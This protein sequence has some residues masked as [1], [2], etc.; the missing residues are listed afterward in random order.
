MC[1]KSPGGR[2]ASSCLFEF[3]RRGI[4]SVRFLLV[5]LSCRDIIITVVVVI[6]IVVVTFIIVIDVI[7][8]V[9]VVVAAPAPNT[10]VSNYQLINEP[11][12]EPLS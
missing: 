12:N 7:V 11:D 9:V 3:N 1:T 6:I 10:P 4:V 2:R 5:E 8:V